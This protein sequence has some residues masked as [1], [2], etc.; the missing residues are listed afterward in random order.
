MALH[1]VASIDDEAAGPS[2]SVPSLVAALNSNG[3]QASVVT[4]S[5]AGTSLSRGAPVRSFM[6][7]EIRPAILR[8]LGRSRDLNRFLV[9]GHYDLI[10]AHGLWMMPTIY[11]ARNAINLGKP[12]VIAPRGMLGQ[13]ALKYSQFAKK[14]FGALYQNRIL[15]KVSCF[16]ATAESEVEDIRRLGI[17]APVAI[18][19]NGIEIPSAYKGGAPREDGDPYI[20]SLG[21]VHP[22]KA[23]DRLIQAFARIHDK[24]PNWRLRIVGPS[25]VGYAKKLS[26]LVQDLCLDPVVSIEGP[27]F[28][29]EKA[30]I[31]ERASIFALP[32]LHENF[33]MTVAESLAVGTPVISTRGAPWQGLELNRCGWW[34]DHGVDAMACALQEAMSLPSVELR[35]MGE[36]G[37]N[38]MSRDF[39]W[40]NIASRAADLYRWLLTAEGQPSF[41]HF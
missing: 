6:P 4:L 32:T 13:D 23:L 18:I 29:E 17:K 2:Y 20:L 36:R 35:R 31:M 12:L 3:H 5:N 8:R 41:V 21:R 37:R 19:P 9:Q 39:G 7:D 10:H 16:H 25:E 22:K 26:D 15:E 40:S 11:G 38:W 24:H 1:P 33:A 14:A 34:V 27:V 28:G 30:R